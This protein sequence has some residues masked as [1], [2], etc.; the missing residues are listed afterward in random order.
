MDTVPSSVDVYSGCGR[1]ASWMSLVL[2][3]SGARS[4][5][6]RVALPLT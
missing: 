5:Q 2:A 1:A 3:V 6:T 4:W